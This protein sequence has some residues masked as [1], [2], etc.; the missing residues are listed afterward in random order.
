MTDDKAPSPLPLFRPLGLMILAVTLAGV[1]LWLVGPLRDPRRALLAD[2]ETWT[3]QLQNFAQSIDAAVRSDSDML[4]IDYA[5]DGG[6]GLQPLS[7]K[8]VERLKYKPD[9]GRRLVIA[10]LSVGEAEEYRPYWKSAWREKPP[11]WVIAENCR[12]PKNYLV[13]FW[14][15]GWRDIIFAGDSSYLA[16]IRAVGF[17]GVY[18]DRVDV[19]S[20]IAEREPHA[21]AHM[22]KFVK[23]FATVARARDP[24]FLVIVQNAEELLE[25]AAY[26]AAIDAVAKED[27]LYGVAGTGER[28]P[29]AMVADS[30]RLLDVLTDDGKPVFVVEYLTNDTA[31]AAAKA[32]LGELGFAGVFPTRALDGSNP[33]QV[34]VDAVTTAES[35]QSEEPESGTPEYARVNCDGVWKRDGR[36][37]TAT[38]AP[39]MPKREP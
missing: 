8:T 7:R 33:V 28:N 2:V 1:A 31:I 32:E 22:I 3:Y 15:R 14:E 29:G 13:R 19:Y 10:Y 9:G 6:D 23:D 21:R 12:W 24:G 26:R 30:T 37:P 25:D 4:V 34:H 18:L 5:I 36:E 17:D 16:A 39:V 38:R 20:D 11:A 27:L 35:R